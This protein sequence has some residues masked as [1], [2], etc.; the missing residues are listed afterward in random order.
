MLSFCGIEIGE[1]VQDEIPV[2]PQANSYSVTLQRVLAAQEFE[3]KS[4]DKSNED[5]TAWAPARVMT[6][7]NEHKW[8]A[9]GKHLG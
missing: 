4:R 7:P 3:E 2:D 1:M 9:E 6:V 5:C 8:T